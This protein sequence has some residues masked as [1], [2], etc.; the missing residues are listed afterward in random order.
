MALD[1]EEQDQLDAIKTWWQVYGKI[2]TAVVVVAA[3]S[4]VGYRGWEYYKH[5]Q[6]SKAVM[7]YDQLTQAQRVQDHKKVRDIA[8]QIVDRYG[9]TPYAGMAALAAAKAAFDMTDLAGAKAQLEWVSGNAR[10]DEMRDVARLRLA[11]VLLDE[12]KF[13]EALKVLETKPSDAFAGLFAERKA[14][15]LLAEGKP[16]EAKAALQVALDKSDPGSQYRRMLELKLDN[17]GDRK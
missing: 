2:V 7:L 14:D 9:R 11:G 4:I 15:V 12:K 6:A 16:A 10:S 13:A 17:L 8:G 5:Q 1:L 3:L